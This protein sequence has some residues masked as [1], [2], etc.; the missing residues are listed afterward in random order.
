MEM[1]SKHLA[2]LFVSSP[3]MWRLS[4][5][6]PGN[7]NALTSGLTPSPGGERAGVWDL[8]A[9]RRFL[10]PGIKILRRS[11]EKMRC[12]LRS[13]TLPSPIRERVKP[14]GVYRQAHPEG[15]KRRVAGLDADCARCGVTG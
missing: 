7:A 13:H 4:I 10:A 9:W 8:C 5:F 12:A 2:A 3:L 1:G 11:A 14:L 6:S 15:D